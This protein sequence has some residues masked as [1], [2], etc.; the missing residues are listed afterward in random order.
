MKSA[1][2]FRLG[3]SCICLSVLLVSLG[4]TL[5]VSAQDHGVGIRKSCPTPAKVG[6]LASCTMRVINED[7]FGD[8]IEVLE[9]WDIVGTGANQFRV[10]ATGN[11]PIIQVSAGVNCAADP[12]A[13]IGLTFPCS[14]PGAVNGSGEFVRVRSTYTVPDW[15]EDPL[16]DQA[17]AIVRD[18]CDVQPVGCNP[19]PQLQQ[20]GAA[21][22]IFEPDLEVTKTGPDQAKVGDEICYQIGFANTSTGTGFPGFENCT[23]T[24]TVLGDLGAFVAGQ[25]REFC[26][27]TSASDPDPLENTATITCGVVGFDNELSDSDDHSVDLIDPSIEVTKSGPDIAKVG[28]EFCWEI[29]FENTGTGDLQNC[30]GTDSFLGDLGAFSAG[31]TR[32]FCHTPT[33]SD[34]NP[35]E[36]TATI[37]CD[38]AGFDNQV[39][40]WDDHSVDL[41]DP[42]IEVTKTGPDSAKVGDEICWEIGFESTGSGDLENCTGSDS[43]LGDLGAFE[44]GVTRSFCHTATSGDPDPIENVAT[45]TC[46]VAGFDN[47]VSDWDDH[48]VDLI[49]PSVSLTKQ[50]HPDPVLVGGT[51]NWSIHIENTGTG[52]L[53]CLLNDPDAGF[54]DEPLS[55]DPGES[56]NYDASR[57]VLLAD[58]PTISNTASVYCSVAGFDND[59]SDEDSADCEVEIPGE[60]VCR[61]PGFWG[62]HAGTEHPNSTNLTQLVIDAA[63]G[64]LHV[65][66]TTVSNTDVGSEHS[67]IEAMCVRV[68]GLQQRQLA[69]QL[70]A[71]ALNCMISNG[72]DDCAG[73]SVEGLFA[74]ANAACAAADE[75][76][77]YYIDRV[78]CF[79]NGGQWN[80]DEGFCYIDPEDPNNC[81][82]RDLDYSTDIFD[83]VS[84]L[85]GPAGSSRAC[86]AATRNDVFIVP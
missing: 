54:I 34:P 22:S 71:M 42:A 41:I 73:T 82:N 17:N 27:T 65:C 72:S 9:F 23:G 59:V 61:T 35:I 55:L 38:V 15:A 79:N 67:A 83:G 36:N 66:G 56:A 37:T 84:P 76:L 63:G 69:R 6:D 70:T 18:L 53:D 33:A 14:M 2:R 4:W 39:S 75:N 3:W 12:G 44:A 85:P 1:S 7:D 21:V 64:E 25:M 26:Y 77:D 74:D 24:D 29:G 30:T 81:Q 16:L 86:N 13:P 32:S 19:N 49:D 46:D 62:T 48:S 60:E 5:S 20:F 31:V 78:D 40:D 50:C 8:T 11:L 80:D 58:F 45:I 47:Q 52:S 28:D 68:G 43:F 10:P 57:T 51:I